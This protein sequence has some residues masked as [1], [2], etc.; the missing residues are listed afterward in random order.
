MRAELL[1]EKEGRD[2]ENVNAAKM[3]EERQSTVVFFLVCV[4]SPNLGGISSQWKI[5]R[6]LNGHVA[7]MDHVRG[8][9]TINFVSLS[10]RS[11]N[12]FVWVTWRMKGNGRVG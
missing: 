12:G 7:Q 3:A 10:E 2:T 1:A 9:Y 11:S 6:S 5:H 4:V 8:D